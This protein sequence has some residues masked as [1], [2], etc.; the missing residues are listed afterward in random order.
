LPNISSIP[1]PLYQPLDPYQHVVDNRP[2]LGLIE[3]ITAVNSQV[4]NNTANLY[5]AAG[6][7]GSMFNRLNQSLEQNGD[8]KV[9]AVDATNHSI[10]A[11]VD[12]T[13][14]VRMTSLERAKISLIAP[15]ATSLNMV[16]STISGA[17][18]FD[19][20][21][22]TFGGSDTIQWVYQGGKVTAQTDFPAAVRHIHYYGLVPVDQNIISPNDQDFYVTSLAT[23]YQED[24]LRVFVNGVRLDPNGTVYVPTGMPGT[25]TYVAMTYTEDT[26]TGGIVTSGG[27]S[28]ST[29]LPSGASIIVD[30]N[31]LY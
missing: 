3:R 17:I 25:V 20:T 29:T 15:E 13:D 22:V 4:D 7:A 14:F 26:A 10:E 16:V 31:Q 18:A 23:A 30:F 5:S 21:T 1:V 12:T 27:F 19:N 11:H 8:L 2:I 9:A 28:L 6:S 24:S